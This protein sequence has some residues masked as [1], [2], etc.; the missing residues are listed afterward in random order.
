MR[1]AIA[2]EHEA[3]YATA[4]EV[5]EIGT[6]FGDQDLIADRRTRAG[7]RPRQTGALRGGPTAAGRGDGDRHNAGSCRRSSRGSSTATRSGSGRACTSC[8]ALASGPDAL[9][10][11]CEQQPDMVAH[12][13]V[14]LVHRAEIMQL[15]GAWDAA[16]E[17]ARRAGERFVGGSAQRTGL[18]EGV[19]PTGRGPPASR[20][21]ER[22]RGV[23]PEA[24]RRGFEPQP[25]LAL[26]RLAEGSAMPRPS[27]MRPGPGRGLEAHARAALLP[28]YVEIMLA[29][30][31]VEEA[32]SGVSRAREHLSVLTGAT[33]CR[34]MSA[35]ARGAL[36]LA[37]GESPKRRSW[38]S[39]RHCEPGRSSRRR[40]RP[41][42]SA[43]S[44]RWLPRRRATRTPPRGSC[45]AARG[46]FDRAGGGSGRRAGG[47]AHA[48]VAQVGTP[49][50]GSRSASCRC[51]ASSPAARRTSP[52]QPSS[53]SASGRSTGT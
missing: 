42:A 5:A 19:L 51:Y 52:S 45:D 44:W 6:R 25:G 17:E 43:S 4:T 34:A 23:V 46:V 41:R 53:C 18:R 26:L 47:L 22:C 21:A 9:T 38:R 16:L 27:A 3:G 29:A 36:A 20:R 28:A 14:C 49:L 24:S 31:E 1:H 15:Q 40:T 12:T 11:W 2:G 32:R 10:R 13:G 39:V 7:S 35:Q 48:R 30:G 33:C 50:T 37:E 8:A